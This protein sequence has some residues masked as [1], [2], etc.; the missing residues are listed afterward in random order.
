MTVLEGFL[1]TPEAIE[2]FGGRSF[3]D[4]MLRFEAALARAQARVGLIDPALA[5]TVANTCRVD[6]FDVPKI[7]RESGHAG[8]LAIPLIAA[9]KEAIGLFNPQA[10]AATHVGSTSQ[11]VIDTAMALVTRPVLDAIVQ[12]AHAIRGE[13]LRLAEQHAETPLLAR[14]LGQPASVTSFG[15]KCVLWADAVGRCLA[16]LCE[17]APTALAV[18]LGGAVGTQAE[19]RGQG[20]A[21][22]ALMAAELGLS[23]PPTPRHTLRDAWVALGCDIGL[24][25]GTLGKIARDL[26]LMAQFEVGEVSEPTGKGR[27]TSSA[28]PHKRN[29]VACMTALAAAQRAPQAVAALLGAMPQEHERALGHWQAELAE[30]SQLMLCAHGASRALASALPGLEVHAAR[31]RANLEALRAQLPAATA[32]EW[33]DPA[34]AAHAG[35]LARA[36]IARLREAPSG[37]A[38]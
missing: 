2:S 33:F 29:P 27:G 17:T 8:S 16:R 36:Q 18:Q 28:M 30:W 19:L 6:L 26:S 32:A 15:W 34:L 7:V 21:I 4:A 10:V 11:D 31:M 13:L 35:T 23:A 24:L 20:A 3:V 22:V 14:T 9:L 38:A 1:S 5:D 37:T 12:D 25:V